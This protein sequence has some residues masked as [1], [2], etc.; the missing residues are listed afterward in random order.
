MMLFSR[1]YIEVMLQ[2]GSLIFKV[3]YSPNIS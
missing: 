1:S 3:Y 2:L